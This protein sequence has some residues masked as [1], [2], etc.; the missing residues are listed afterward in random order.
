MAAS[1]DTLRN[2]GAGEAGEGAGQ[3]NILLVDDQPSR[4][5]TYQ[6]IL[7]ELGQNLVMAR[8]GV[9]ALE[10]LMRTEFAVVLLDVS[11]PDMDGFETAKL[12]HEHPR[13]EKTP[14][15]FVTGVHI[16]ELDRLKGYKAG[17]FDYVSI[18]VVPEILRSKVAVVVELYCKRRELRELNDNLT[19]ANERLA[20]ANSD[21]QLE[22]TRELETL[23]AALRRS[24]EELARANRKLQSEVIE[25]AR[26]EHS[27][28]EADRHKDEFLAMLAHELRNPLAP[29][30]NA[31]QLMRALPDAGPQYVNL[32]EM[33]DRQLR[34][35]TRLV[36]DLL[37]VSRITRG[38]IKLTREPIEVS[39]LI[40]RA[41]ETIQPLIQ[42]QG[43]TLEI[44][45]PAQRLRIFGDPMRLIQIVGNL[46][47][48]AAKY[49]APG[50][51]IHLEVLALEREV[52]I[53]VRDD[54][55]GIPT[56]LLPKIFELFTQLDRRLDRPQSGLGIGLALV[57]RLAEMHGGSVHAHSEGEGRGSE[58][59]IR[60]PLMAEEPQTEG[61]P[62]ITAA[63]GPVSLVSR[64]ILVADDNAD[65]MESL[66]TLL[67]LEGH[68]VVRAA[69]GPLALAAAEQHLPEVVLL[70]I[71][72]P[73]LD[74]YEVARRI[75]EQPWGAQMLLVALTG[76]GQDSD[77]R[78]SRDAG[79]DCHLVKP[80]N[81]EE[82]TPLLA[83]LPGRRALP[84]STQP[85]R[86]G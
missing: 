29:I 35:L 24:N 12:I 14:I 8:S 9:E 45:A 36:D 33:V 69:N 39:T 2:A 46:L 7:Q 52:E 44:S 70:D 25:R 83:G 27:L 13:F 84:F 47:S 18:P 16:S 23:N 49:T 3:V 78:R 79:F 11:M 40:T 34:H 74:G 51:H 54:G 48:N 30:H 32:R 59:V 73:L 10:K 66:A 58:F 81:L 41:V 19:R 82:L 17:A 22:K 86:T 80:L 71:G 53:R 72:M 85:T 63:R 4:L 5:L 42:E 55:V 75:R 26:V 43:H 21:L 15:I 31:V 50:G 20:R 56:D 77:R 64:R 61:R 6:T 65:A 38:K 1:L 57:Q 67:E 76:W 62:P 68:Q 60:L 28:K 37:D